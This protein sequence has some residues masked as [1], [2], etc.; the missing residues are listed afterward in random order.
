MEIEVNG[1]KLYYEVKGVGKPLIMV[2][3]NGED[4]TI[5]DVAVSLLQFYFTCY[6]FDTRG[7]GQSSK[8]SEFHYQDMADDYKEVIQKLNLKE[9]T[10]YG[11]SDGGIIGL[12]IASQSDLI[13]N[14]IISGANITTNGVKKWMKNLIKVMNFFKKDPL[15]ELMLKE[16]NIPVDELEKIQCPTL[17]LAGSKDL[18]LESETRKIAE[19]IPGSKCTIVEGEGHGSYIVHK[20]RIGELILEFVKEKEEN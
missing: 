20:D 15:M 6:V 9:V 4:H 11:F 3:G 19:H 12:L 14:L 2:H 18:I 16:P 17:V 5:F 10:F 13:S 7:H 1:V 8:V